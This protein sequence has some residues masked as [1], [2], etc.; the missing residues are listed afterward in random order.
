MGKGKVSS[1]E[2]EHKVG[3]RK[4]P[5]SPDGGKDEPGR[6]RLFPPTL[7]PLPHPKCE[8]GCSFRLRKSLGDS[9]IFVYVRVSVCWEHFL[10]YGR[11]YTLHI[12]I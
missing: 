6:K 2:L 9:G 5:Q 1:P 4:E 7:H 3:S 8:A 11:V 10:L 12:D